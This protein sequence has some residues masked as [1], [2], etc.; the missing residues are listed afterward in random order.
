[1]RCTPMWLVLGLRHQV[2][3]VGVGGYM[4]VYST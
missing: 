2:A 3:Q 1:M 4:D